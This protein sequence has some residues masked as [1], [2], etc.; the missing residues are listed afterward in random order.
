M[1]ITLNREVADFLNNLRYSVFGAGNG[2]QALAAYLALKG[3]NVCLWDRNVRKIR[4]L[5]SLGE[6]KLSGRLECSVKIDIYTADIEKAVRFADVLMIVSTADAHSELA[7]RMADYLEDGQVVILNPGRTCGA[8][9]F[10]NELQRVKCSA[11]LYVAEAQTL[12]FACRALSLGHVN[13]IGIKDKVFLAAYPASDTPLVIECVKSVIPSFYA[14]PDVL[15]TSLEN[16]GAIFHPCVILFNAAT[17]E[18]GDKFF[19]YRDMTPQIAAFIEKFDAERLAVGKAYGIN[20][21]GVK[22]WIS[23]AYEGTLGDTLCEKIVNNPAYFDIMAP[24]SLYTRQLMED[25]PTGVLPI[26]DLGKAAG[27]KMTL[28]SAMID[29]ISSLL[30]VDFRMRGRTLDNLC[31]NGLTP[32]EIINKLR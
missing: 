30:G 21:I 22:E 29:L 17:I 27:L 9:E 31:L 20:L 5:E 25:I 24:S 14:A 18:R 32:E 10:R 4:D 11:K 28:F 8:L 26:L 23:T 15:H 3:K 19:F 1:E 7:G 13:V 12:L 6:I 16:V 2:G